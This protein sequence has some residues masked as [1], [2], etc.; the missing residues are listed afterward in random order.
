MIALPWGSE[1][2]S[3]VSTHIALN[4]SIRPAQKT[5]HPREEDGLLFRAE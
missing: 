4:F 3:E 5:G 1:L 2:N